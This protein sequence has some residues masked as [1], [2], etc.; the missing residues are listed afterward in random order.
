MQSKVFSTSVY[1]LW[2]VGVVF[3]LVLPA[4]K[5]QEDGGFSSGNSGPAIESNSLT[6]IFSA[7]LESSDRLILTP[8]I[9]AGEIEKAQNLS[10]VHNFT[11]VQ[12][13][14]GFFNVNPTYNSNMF[15]WFFPAAVRCGAMFFLLQCISLKLTSDLCK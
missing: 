9:T 2:T 1:L 11:R 7:N 13:Y 12:S 10:R 15:F 4:T 5:G 3:T 8:Y 14:S 6:N